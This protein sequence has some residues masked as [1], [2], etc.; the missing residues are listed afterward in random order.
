MSAEASLLSAPARLLSPV[1]G[2]PPCPTGPLIRQRATGA[3]SPSSSEIH[4][5]NSVPDFYDRL[6]FA[7]ATVLTVENVLESMKCCLPHT[8]KPCVKFV[9][10]SY[11]FGVTF[12]FILCAES[13]V[14]FPEVRPLSDFDIN[15]DL[16]L[17][18]IACDYI[19][20]RYLSGG[21]LRL[22]SVCPA[23][24]NAI[25]ESIRHITALHDALKTKILGAPR[26]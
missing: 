18:Y 8:I 23:Q 14:Y 2:F 13:D 17:E 10:R 24:Y 12:T 16:A 21:P 19:R 5:P 20:Y 22:S 26:P 11:S 15:A 7:P 4:L 3:D 6:V 9:P 1:C 25:V